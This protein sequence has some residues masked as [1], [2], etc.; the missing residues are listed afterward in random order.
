MSVHNKLPAHWSKRKAVIVIDKDDLPHLQMEDDG[1][2]LLNKEVSVLTH[3]LD[4]NDKIIQNIIGSG[5]DAPGDMLLQNPYYPNQYEVLDKAP[6]QFAL[7]RYLIFSTLCGHLGAKEVIIEEVEK[8]TSSRVQQLKVE[9]KIGI[10]SG[11]ITGQKED[12]ESM[13]RKMTLSHDFTGGKPNI[14]KAKAWLRRT[15][16]INDVEMFTLIEMRENQDN[17][18][19]TRKMTL[20][21]SDE[22]KQLFKVIGGLVIPQYLTTI[23][24]SYEKVVSEKTEYKLIVTV[25]F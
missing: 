19:K 4:E 2:I 20:D 18:V 6:Q 14:E 24:G 9:G 10:G 23:K 8:R 1:S 21:L 11:N 22:T 7:Q 17:P 16:L 5:L 13:L 3:P 25:N 15:R 12:L